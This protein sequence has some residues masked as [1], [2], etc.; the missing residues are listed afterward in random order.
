MSKITNSDL[1]KVLMEKHGLTKADAE[2]FVTQMFDTLNNGLRKDKLVKI[3]GLGTFKVISVSSR[4]SVDVNT[5]KPIIIEGRDK[6]SFTPD[7]T[8]RDKVNAPFA[9]FDTVVINEGVEFS[10]I[11]RRFQDGEDMAETVT[12]KRE[13]SINVP[14]EMNADK[15][16]SAE[17][18]QLQSEVEQ[19]SAA[20]EQHQEEQEQEE[21]HKE[22]QHKEE[23]KHQPADEPVLQSSEDEPAPQLSRDEPAPLSTEEESAPQ[24]TEEGP[25]PQSD[26]KKQVALSAQTE[27]KSTEKITEDEHDVPAIELEPSADAVQKPA[28]VVN[29]ETK[30]QTNSLDKTDELQHPSRSRYYLL[31]VVVAAVLVLL[32][33]GSVFY[34][35]N[36]LQIRDNRI[37]RLEKMV[38]NVRSV[39]DVGRTSAEPKNVAANEVKSPDKIA[40]TKLQSRATGATQT[41]AMVSSYDKPVSTKQR[42]AAPTR[43]NDNNHQRPAKE[44]P[45]VEDNAAKASTSSSLPVGDDYNKDIRIRTGAY[46]IVGI[47]K[48]VTVRQGQSLSSISRVYLGPGME[49]YVEAVNSG[50]KAFNAGEKINIPK[51]QLKK[52]RK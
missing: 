4:K 10:D 3:K 15:Q 29:V 26:E 11:D 39:P 27:L 5:G 32:L 35:V 44:K 14:Q 8:L 46:D 41:K 24:S 25:A 21:Q 13:T 38:S 28:S 49:C 36:E 18:E 51:V 52:R 20:K 23:Q 50:K 34:F 42:T 7:N 33:G 6:I 12:D 37:S 45:T 19:Q 16:L 40:D 1:A 9:Q 2:R 31:T 30:P 22:E 17:E 47:D 43:D 48:T